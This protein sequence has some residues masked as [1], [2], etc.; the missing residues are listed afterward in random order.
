MKLSARVSAIGYAESDTPRKP[1]IIVTFTVFIGGFRGAP[2][3]VNFQWRRRDAERYAWAKQ[4]KI[5]QR[6]DIRFVLEKK[7]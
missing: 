3:T 2:F 5:G 7:K 1:Q 4:L 6:L